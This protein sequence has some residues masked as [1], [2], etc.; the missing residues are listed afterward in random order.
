MGIIQQ[1]ENDKSEAM[2]NYTMLND[3][4]MKRWDKTV[5]VPQ[6]LQDRIAV[7]NEKTTWLVIT[8]SWCGDAAHLLPVMNKVAELNENIDF[9][10]VLTR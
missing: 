7:F 6:E 3:R 5:K 2:I 9:K 8:E 10:I 1:Q 4:R